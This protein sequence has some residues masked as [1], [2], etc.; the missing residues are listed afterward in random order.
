M[1]DETKESV[2]K[3]KYWFC[4]QL[5]REV[6]KVAAEEG[7]LPIQQNFF[8]P[9]CHLTKDKRKTPFPVSALS[10][11]KNIVLCGHCY[12][13]LS[14]KEDDTDLSKLEFF[15]LDNC[16]YLF[17]NPSIIDHFIDQG[18][19]LLLPAWLD[20]WER[21]LQA[22]GFDQT[23]ARLFFQES[24]KG[25]LLLDTFCY[26]NSKEKAQELSHYIGLPCEIIPVGLDYLRLHVKNLLL[27][28]QQ[29]LERNKAM[30]RIAQANRK[31]S[32]YAMALDI[33]M[34]TR[35]FMTEK[36]ATQHLEDLFRLLFAADTVHYHDWCYL[37]AKNS[38]Y[39]LEE[40]S[41]GFYF[42]LTYRQEVLGTMEVKNLPFSS[43]L[44]DYLNLAIS[45]SGVCGLTIANAQK[46][47]RIKEVEKSLRHAK[48]QAEQAS[49]AKSSFL[50]NMSHE[51]RTP[52]H[53]IFGIL[54]V[55]QDSQ[56]G[57][58]QKEL[59]Q[60][61][62]NSAKVLLTILNDVLDLSKI[63]AKKI[64]LE[65]KPLDVKQLLQEVKAL[66]SYS[67]QSKSLLFH[68]HVDSAVPTEML[69]DPARLRQVLYNL[70]SNAIKFTEEGTIELTVDLVDCQDSS[71]TEKGRFTKKFSSYVR[72]QIR[73]TGIGIAP[74]KIPYLFEAF[75]QADSSITRKYG[76]TGLGLTISK[77]FV[78]LMGGEM[79]VESEVEKGSL[80]WFT[81]PLVSSS[82]LSSREDEEDRDDKED[83][84]ISAAALSSTEDGLSIT[85]V[86]PLLVVDDNPVNRKLTHLQLSKLGYTQIA[87][88]SNGEEAVEK[89][90]RD[91]YSLIL[92]DLQMPE[93]D[94]YE[95]TRLIRQDEQA[96]ELSPV[97]IVAMTAHAMED[98]Q[99]RCLEVGMNDFITKPVNL[100]TLEKV[101]QKWLSRA[102]K[103]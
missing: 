79:G 90:S 14:R 101:L 87:D 69:V 12:R 85:E 77:E 27:Q 40:D 92:M 44:Q 75:T 103:T 98:E 29:V 81:I 46:F 31:S 67:Y 47:E 20:R 8:A 70:T 13:L 36:E 78:T 97:P 51:I 72:F 4:R 99:S 41:K 59:L 49:E 11:E 57:K 65:Y 55:L 62:Q 2:T 43:Y 89:V 19:F 86:Y 25:F 30:K 37:S 80:F 96:R 22:W 94:G 60:L 34:N 88:A 76:G 16:F 23:G 53:G 26:P 7:L 68:I 15:S 21:Y 54:E 28:Q 50:A 61:V 35:S 6:E 32:D 83:S 1:D 9:I 10:T 39:F 74:E 93:L 95:A 33:L 84:A 100:E 64:V 102:T 42:H 73:D 3:I 58:E 38:G 52:L 45:L 63:E 18:Q 24:V 48:K 5:Q 56:L 82:H 71:L 91:R 17:A 66:L